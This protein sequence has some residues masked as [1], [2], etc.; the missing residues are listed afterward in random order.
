M[1]ENKVKPLAGHCSWQYWQMTCRD[2]HFICLM[3]TLGRTTNPKKEEK[4]S[5]I[6][7]IISYKQNACKSFYS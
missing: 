3:E 2:S 1:D 5:K 7:C 4:L 6:I